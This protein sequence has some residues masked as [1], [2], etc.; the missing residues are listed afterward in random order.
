MKNYLYQKVETYIDFFLI[1]LENSCS[2]DINYTEHGNMVA[3]FPYNITHSIDE[4]A[5]QQRCEE[6]TKCNGYSI[7]YNTWTSSLSSCNTTNQYI[8]SDCSFYSKI[9]P[10]SLL[11]CVPVTAMPVNTTLKST[12]PTEKQITLEQ[13]T[14]VAP[15]TPMDEPINVTRL[16]TM[17]SSLNARSINDVYIEQPIM[18][19]CLQKR[20]PNIRIVIR[21][22]EEN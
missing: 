6:D 7:D 21:K 22:E 20:E 16:T 19:L 18:C 3:M 9:I 11:S 15:H 5:C 8:S 1:L 12:T 2:G 10:T 4:R 14:H 17:A 13:S